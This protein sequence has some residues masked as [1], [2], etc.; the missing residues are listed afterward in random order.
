MIDILIDELTNSIKHRETDAEFETILALATKEEIKALENWQFDWL[1][2]MT[3][4]KV[5]KLI[6]TDEPNLIQGLISLEIQKGFVF[7]NILE[8]AP[9]NVGKKG[10]YKGVG[11]NLF[12]FAC[13]VSFESG[14]DGYVSFIA[15]N[16]LI[17][18]YETLLEAQLISSQRMIIDTKAAT[19]LVKHYFKNIEL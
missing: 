3:K 9:F 18:H 15:K 19:K 10:I 6:K 5:Y 17:K 11:G 8:N 14:F 7:V 13:K 16:Q 1:T 2:E 4:G 12:A